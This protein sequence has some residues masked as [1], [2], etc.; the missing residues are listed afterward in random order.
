M[1]TYLSRK[2]VEQGHRVTALI[3]SSRSAAKLPPGVDTVLGDPKG[4]GEWQKKVAGHDVVI[5]LAGA[6][7]FTHWTRKTRQLILDSRVFTTRNLVDALLAAGEK[8]LLLSASAVG[9]YG[10]REDDRIL[11]ESTPPG[12]DFLGEVGV[13]WE[14]EAMRAEKGGVRVVLCRLGIVL[15]KDGGA[16]P[17]MIPAF[18]NY[19]GSALGSG[20]QWFSWIH[21]EDVCRIFFFAMENEALSGPINCTAPYPV[22]NEEFTRTFAKVLHKPL[23]LPAVP[24]FLLRA[25]LG[26]F[27]DVILKGQRAYPARLLEAGFQFRFPTLREALENLLIAR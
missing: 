4:P 2:M 6:S 13:K 22:T 20:K 19:A 11:D 5:N 16:L 26:E 3:R 8:P 27:A 1:G 7:I 21:E 10:G 15:G 24:R 25:I 18:S 14:A 9:Y 17:R 12:T 23:I